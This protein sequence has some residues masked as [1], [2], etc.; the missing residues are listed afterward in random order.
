MLTSPLTQHLITELD[1]VAFPTVDHIN[2]IIFVFHFCLEI[3]TF[4][5]LM[6]TSN[7]VI[8]NGSYHEKA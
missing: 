5:E 1:K 6:K 3:K 8:K 4:W 7:S 2:V